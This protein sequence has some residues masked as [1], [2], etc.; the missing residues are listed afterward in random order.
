MQKN[1]RDDSSFK[2]K[3]AQQKFEEEYT[4]AIVPADNKDGFKIRYYYYGLWYIWNLPEHTLKKR[5]AIAFAEVIGCL[6]LYVVAFFSGA[7]INSLGLVAY[8]VLLS[9][10]GFVLEFIGVCQFVFAHYRTTKSNYKQADRRIRNTTA[11]VFLCMIFAFLAGA[12][13]ML[14]YSSIMVIN[15]IA[16]AC[17]AGVALL[18]FLIREQYKDIP[19]KTEKNDILDHIEVFKM[20]DDP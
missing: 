19:F 1:L 14:I 9:L 11:F 8:P 17:Y 5:K 12:I 16:I 20:D 15:L 18:S 13:Y 2:I 7:P 3:T 10:C 6:L 4:A